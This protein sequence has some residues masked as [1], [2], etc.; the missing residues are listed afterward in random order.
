MFRQ[1][2]QDGPF[3]VWIALDGVA[4]VY[5][6]EIS[7]VRRATGQPGLTPDAKKIQEIHALPV[8]SGSRSQGAGSSN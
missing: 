7:I 5:V 8:S 4:E 1:A 2:S 6:D 3:R